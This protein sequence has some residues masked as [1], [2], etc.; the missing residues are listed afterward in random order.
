MSAVFL[1]NTH[2]EA[3]GTPWD[4]ESLDAVAAI[5]RPVY[6]DGARLFNASV[7]TGIAVA[8]YAVPRRRRDDLP[9]EGPRCAGRV[10]G[11]R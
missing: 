8:E 4:L 11:G 2:M 6:M 1:E 10:A 5:G 9:V 7:A 3:C